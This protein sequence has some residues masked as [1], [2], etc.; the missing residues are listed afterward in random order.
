MKLVELK[1]QVD[2][3]VNKNLGNLEVVDEN[4]IAFEQ[5]IIDHDQ[6]EDVALISHGLNP[7]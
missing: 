1:Q 7:V 4:R 3:L 6:G 2:D 5:V